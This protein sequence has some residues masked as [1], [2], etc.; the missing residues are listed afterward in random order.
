MFVK[1]C[2]CEKVS[3]SVLSYCN[4]TAYMHVCVRGECACVRERVRE[5]RC[6][7]FVAQHC[8]YLHI[9]IC[10]REKRTERVWE[11]TCAC[12]L[13]HKTANACVRVCVRQV[14]CVSE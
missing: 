5:G 1:V 9:S 8:Y 12:F 4:A 7:Y 11:Y 10:A 2:V 6:M 13:S 3:T 14:V